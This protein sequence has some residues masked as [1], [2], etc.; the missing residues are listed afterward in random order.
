LIYSTGLLLV[1]IAFALLSLSCGTVWLRPDQLVGTDP[2]AQMAR[3]I[4]T[5]LRLPRLVLTLLVGGALG[6]SGAV[7]QGLTRNP[8]GEPG[9]L[10]VSAGGSFGA[11]VAIYFGLSIHVAAAGPLLALLG[12][13]IAMMLTYALGRGGGTVALILAG[14]AVTALMWALT[15]LALNLADNPYAAYEMST[16]LLGSLANKGWPQV[17]LA[18]PF[19]L[20][21]M[22]VLAGTGRSLDALTLGE[23]Q[24]ESLGINVE[25]LNMRA[26]VG[27]AMA[28][29]GATAVT[30]NIGFIGLV[31]PHLMRPLVGHQPGRLLWPSTLAGAALLLAADIA[32]RVVR[33]GPDIKV[34]VFTSIVGA[35]FF[36]WLIIRMRRLAP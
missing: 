4:V 19:I 32:T 26:L 33:L 12:A 2:S 23:I 6:L 14:S 5:E 13:A 10:G 29:G 27:T 30:G 11:V 7:L 8:L 16:W 28:I 24:A 21:G 35:P 36:F 18:A 25:R 1:L 3:L 17:Q 34:G 20:A 22:A 9:L 15:D 31:A